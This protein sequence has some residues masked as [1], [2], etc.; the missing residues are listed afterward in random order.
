MEKRV[1]L[2]ASISLAFT[3]LIMASLFGVAEVGSKVKV[4]TG[5][6]PTK[7]GASVEVE[8]SIADQLAKPVQIVKGR[9]AGDQSIGE[10]PSSL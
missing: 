8:P 2:V 6:Q 5:D 7:A 9:R 4:E 1:E 3:A 10:L